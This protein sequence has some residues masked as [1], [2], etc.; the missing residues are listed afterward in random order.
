MSIQIANTN[1][2]DNFNSWRLNT[3]YIATVISNNVVTVGRDGVDRHSVTV[4]NGHIQGTFTANE[5]RTSTLRSGNTSDPG[6]WLYVLANTSI[7]ATS[8]AISS[9]TTFSG[10]VTFAMSGTDRLNLGEL[11]RIRLS[12]GA[13]GDFLRL[14]GSDDTLAF[15]TLSLR[16]ITDLSTNSAHIILSGANTSFSSGLDSP[17]LIFTGGDSNQDRFEMYLDGDATLGRS[18]FLF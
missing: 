18:E 4:G 17:H 16:D 1:L 11:N 12:G 14:S 3:N 7:N 15:Q 6:G 9:N 8:L 2:G 13:K 10:N 5:L